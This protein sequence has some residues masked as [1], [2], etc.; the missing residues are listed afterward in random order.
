MTVQ[1]KI[2]IALFCVVTIT[3]IWNMT[4]LFLYSLSPDYELEQDSKRVTIGSSTK[5]NIVPRLKKIQEWH[6]CDQ[7][8]P[9][10]Y[11]HFIN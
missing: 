3:D 7:D 4:I 11:L 8:K 5:A 9:S 10:A 6:P 1:L 2:K